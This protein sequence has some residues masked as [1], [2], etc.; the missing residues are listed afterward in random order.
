MNS[1]MELFAGCRAMHVVDSVDRRNWLASLTCKFF[2]LFLF[3]F[4]FFRIHKVC[5]KNDEC[6]P[7][8][9]R[10]WDAFLVPDTFPGASRIPDGFVTPVE[11][12]SD[13]WATAIIDKG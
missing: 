2:C 11:P 3:L 5:C 7:S 10:Q 13:L 12:S 1:V 9:R 8:S 6:F 4:F